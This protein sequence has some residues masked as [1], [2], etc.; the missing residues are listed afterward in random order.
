MKQRRW[1]TADEIL[2]K[3]NMQP[4]ELIKLI[5][6]GSLQP[7]AKDAVKELKIV[8]EL[9]GDE[10]RFLI[11]KIDNPEHIPDNILER[12]NSNVQREQFDNDAFEKS[13]ELYEFLSKL[14]FKAEDVSV[15]E[16]SQGI[17]K[18]TPETETTPA[19][20]IE[21]QA[22]NCF[23]RNGDF[24]TIR[25][26]GTESKPIKHV[27]GLLYIAYLLERPGKSLH[28]LELYRLVS[29]NTPDKTMD[30][31]T[32]ID[33]GL[34]VGNREQAINDYKTKNDYLKELEKYEE[35]KSDYLAEVESNADDRETIMI[36]VETVN[37]MIK[38]I[39]RKLNERNFPGD[40]TKKQS[41]ING[42][43]K[44]AYRK[45]KADDNIKKCVVHLKKQI[46]PDGA[47]GFIYTGEIK[48]EIFL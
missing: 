18:I 40:A 8:K 47:L 13:S 31:R 7:Y 44:T 42:L 2:E 36:N 16:E 35:L 14:I 48:W 20:Q 1:F 15:C 34:N 27:Q 11:S 26:Q 4:F 28:S 3:W 30:E 23:T 10:I 9:T 12:L 37:G 24:W 32:A 5:R 29:S 38:E 17:A 46:K 41:L 25:F 39:Q 22:E 33:D 21:P 6:D 45:I 43:L 19:P